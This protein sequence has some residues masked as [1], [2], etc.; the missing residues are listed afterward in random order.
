M[1][2]ISKSPIDNHSFGSDSITASMPLTGALSAAADNCRSCFP[3]HAVQ[4][5]KDRPLLTYAQTP[6]ANWSAK[7]IFTNSA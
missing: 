4:G 5:S 6:I 3:G 1:I 2:E 7:M